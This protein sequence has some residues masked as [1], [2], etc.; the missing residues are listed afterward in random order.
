MVC[1]RR[2]DGVEVNGSGCAGHWRLLVY[3]LS[4]AV[5]LLTL[6]VHADKQSLRTCVP[7]TIVILIASKVAILKRQWHTDLIRTK[8]E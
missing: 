1:A 3:F 8:L 4:R 6:K 5:V 7:R 2:A